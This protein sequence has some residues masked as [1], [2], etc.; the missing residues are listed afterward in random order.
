[1]EDLAAE[2]AYPEVLGETSATS[3]GDASVVNYCDY[4]TISGFD[5]V[6]VDKESLG[7]QYGDVAGT[8]FADDGPEP[9]L[10]LAETS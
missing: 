10:V 5:V 6:D 2:A 8:G 1:M 4:V 7:F 3:V 9:F